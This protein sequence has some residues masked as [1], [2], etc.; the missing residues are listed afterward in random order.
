M[1]IFYI[2][3]EYTNGN[4]YLGD[5]FEI[6]CL[7]KDSGYIFHSYIKIPSSIPRYIKRLCSVTDMTI[8]DSP[9]F[10][11]IMDDLLE[12][13]ANQDD[14]PTT[15]LVSHG[16]FLSDFPLLMTNCMKYGYDYTRFE[17]Y[18]LID[19]MQVFQ[20]MGYNRPGLDALST[21]NRSHS[22]IE[23]VELLRDIVT[24][25]LG[26]AIITNVYTLDDILQYLSRKLPVS[27]PELYSLANEASS[28]QS[29]EATLRRYS[30]T[31]TALNNKQLYKIAC[32][33]YYNSCNHL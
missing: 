4:F 11:E 3:T 10:C 16:G 28:Y 24:K 32:K 2:V 15:T 29:F 22:A 13:I 7:S 19:S 20:R 23:D 8:Q 30:A 21:T 14:S 31:K 25:T 17:K 26:N 12:F 9:S 6:A 18:N 27:I 33:Y 5:I 1:G